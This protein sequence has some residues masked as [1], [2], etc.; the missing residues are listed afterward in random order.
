MVIAEE[1][2][3]ANGSRGNGL[4]W[5][6]QEA[7]GKISLVGQE[8]W[9]EILETER[10]EGRDPSDLEPAFTLWKERGSVSFQ[11]ACPFQTIW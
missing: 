6:F 5:I 7:N 9:G 3:R 1:A 8:P 4:Q 10:R 11:E 2:E